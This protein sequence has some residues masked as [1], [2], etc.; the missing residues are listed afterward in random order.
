MPTHTQ[1]YCPNPI[2]HYELCIVLSAN[3]A[4]SAKECD[5]E[6]ELSYFGARY[7]SSDL[8]IWLSVDPMVD[9]YPSTSPYAYC[10]NNPVIMI[11]VNGLFDS[12]TRATRV[13]DRAAKKYGE[14]RVSDVYNNTSGGG[15]ANY[16]FSIYGKGKTKYS[17]G[18]GTDEHGGQL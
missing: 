6:T 3:F 13:R 9:K 2:V 14:D 8:S 11:D 5:T 12:E 4:F 10:R 16:S 17:R 15:K 7:Y 18:G 1:T